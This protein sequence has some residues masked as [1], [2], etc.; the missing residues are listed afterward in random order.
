MQ[1][2][3]YRQDFPL[4]ITF[5]YNDE[6]GDLKPFGFPPFDFKVTFWTTSRLNEYIAECKYTDGIPSYVNCKR[7]GD[8]FVVIFDNCD[9]MPGELHSEMISEVPS[10]LY[11]DGYRRDILI[12][13]PDTKLITGP[14]PSPTCAQIRSLLPYIK[15]K[16]LTIESLSQEDLDKIEEGIARRIEEKLNG[17]TAEEVAKLWSQA[18]AEE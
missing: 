9:L 18:T 6:N 15:G 13:H 5:Y 4:V 1:E 17:I 16:D 7:V 3:N 11:P 8:K 12:L 10:E 2:I 14:T